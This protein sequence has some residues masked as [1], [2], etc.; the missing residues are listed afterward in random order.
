MAYPN[1]SIAGY[2]P[3]IRQFFSG[4]LLFRILGKEELQNL[5]QYGYSRAID[6]TYGGPETELDLKPPTKI[7]KGWLGIAWQLGAGHPLERCGLVS[8][9]GVTNPHFRLQIHRWPDHNC[10]YY[11]KSA[12][13]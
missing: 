5:N 10:N 9:T 3:E 8:K 2:R 12:T 13:P 6:T 4:E 1:I 11:A 7:H